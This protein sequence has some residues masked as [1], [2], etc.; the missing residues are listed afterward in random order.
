M[1]STLEIFT[2]IKGLVFDVDGVFTDSQMLVTEQGEFLRSMNTRDGYAVKCAL[3][4]GL[5][6][7]VITGGSSTGVA[8]RLQMLGIASV[9]TRVEHKLPVFHEWVEK[10][11]LAMEEVLYMGD[12]LPDWEVMHAAGMTCCP[13]DAVPEIREISAYISPFKGGQFC[14]RDVIE[15]TLRAQGLWTTTAP[16]ATD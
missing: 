4:A 2:K 15:K 1:G 5:K 6:L 11:G 13:A 7:C 9:Y 3:A 16:G 14:V 8:R 12:D 10:E